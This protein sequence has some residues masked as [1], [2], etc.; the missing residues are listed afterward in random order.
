MSGVPIAILGGG[1]VGMTLALLLAR[2]HVPALVLDARSIDDAKRD[3]RLLALSRGTLDTLGAVVDLPA[4]ALA[5][6]R[7]VV[8]SSRGEFG[9]AV[10][11]EQD[12]GGRPL[13]A[14]VRYGDL[15]TALDAACAARPQVQVRRPC[16]ATAVRQAA[17]AVEV[18][19][20]DGDTLVAPIVVN[21]EG[22]GPSVAAPVARQAALTGD[23]LV[24]GPAAGAAFERFTRD[25]PLA[26]LPLPGPAAGTARPMSLVWCMPTEDADRREQLSDGELLAQ[27]QAEFGER[28]GRVRSIRARGRYPLIEQARDDVREHRVV[29]VGNAAQ[30]LHPVAGQGLNLGVRDCVALA[31][32]IA[33]AAAAG[34]DPL[35]GLPEYER[36]RRAD[37]LAIRSLTRTIP[38]F[39]ATRFG[40]A[41]AAR[42]LGLTLLSI[43]PD[44]RA[45]F[46]RF[47]MFGVRS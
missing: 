36:R 40:P 9:R 16:A 25:G 8:V 18:G 3:R 39:F 28:N 30:T 6:I 34:R 19:L 47:L 17:N 35:T 46:A 44:L 45:E 29:H 2:R 33:A 27:L 38:G 42:S 12:N 22:V 4:G 7:S 13:G 26:L 41:A 1:P 14:T 32:V 31:D 43:F 20:A 37:R 10:L 11:D 23:V 15:L 5:P 21:A 24:E